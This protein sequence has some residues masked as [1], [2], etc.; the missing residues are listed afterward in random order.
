MTSSVKKIGRYDKSI[1]M[2]LVKICG[3]CHDIGKATSYFQKYLFAS[4]EEKKKL[5]GMS[6]TRH[7]LLSAVVSF[8][9]AQA[10]FT[11]KKAKK[12]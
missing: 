1:L 10:E 8:Y 3:L 11:G 7:G 4:D 2:R 5:K 9:A 6:E 12:R